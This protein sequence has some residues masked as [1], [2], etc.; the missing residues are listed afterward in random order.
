M[1]RRARPRRP[2]QA[3]PATAVAR[4]A[5][6]AAASA[7]APGPD[8]RRGARV[9]APP[10]AKDRAAPAVA[11]ARPHPVPALRSR[12]PRASRCAP[13]AAASPGT[14]CRAGARPARPWPRGSDRPGCIH[15]LPKPARQRPAPFPRRSLANRAMRRSSPRPRPAPSRR[16]APRPCPAP[17]SSTCNRRS[18]ATYGRA[19]APRRTQT[20]SRKPRRGRSS[21]RS[22]LRTSSHSCETLPAT[23]VPDFVGAP[24]PHIPMAFRR[25]SA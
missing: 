7:S 18:A 9:A 10:K 8:G 13:Q 5:G 4:G 12:N 19:A 25:V 15:R 24:G 17:G 21:V 22:S 16:P 20:N 23:R 14:A 2:G 1:R 6:R 3:G 11:R